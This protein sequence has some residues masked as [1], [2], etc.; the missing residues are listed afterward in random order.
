M[1]ISWTLRLS[2]W[3]FCPYPGVKTV[4]VAIIPITALR[5][6]RLTGMG[7]VLSHYFGQAFIAAS[8]NSLTR[9]R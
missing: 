2:G 8:K 6:R 9:F 4:A 1:S 5:I 3:A 7:L